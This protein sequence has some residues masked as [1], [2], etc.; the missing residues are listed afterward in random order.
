VSEVAP[1][2]DAPRVLTR[3][4]RQRLATVDE[5][6]DVGRSM[7]RDGREVSLRALATEMGLTP[8]AL[9]R[10]V[11]NLAALNE[12]IS[13]A[14]FVDVVRRMVEAGEPYGEQDPAAQIVAAATAFR[15]WALESKAEFQLVF[16]TTPLSGEHTTRTDSGRQ[17][18]PLSRGV[19]G[20][21]T[22]GV[23]MFADY[24]GGMLARLMRQRPFP[25]P[26]V[27]D[28]D[29]EFVAIHSVAR[30]GQSDLLQLLGRDA[31]GMV[32]L[33]EFGWAQLLSI[34][35]LEVFGHIRPRLITSGAVFQAQMREIGN[36]VGMAGDWDRLA[37]VSE[38]VLA[39]QARQNAPTV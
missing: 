16:A 23:E 9:Y 3:R 15:A 20:G 36:R 1:E 35:A 39:R 29:P 31:L 21:A 33:F 22:R 38:E 32:W 19:S 8:P 10:Y 12:L 13:D 37:V 17:S 30:P 26:A 11:D 6:I 7:L 24:F 28:L 14:S 25:V 27:E 4:E 5:I 2:A 34:V 18:H